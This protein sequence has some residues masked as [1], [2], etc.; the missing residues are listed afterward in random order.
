MLRVTRTIS[1]GK[2]LDF[3]SRLG[4]DIDVV[5]RFQGRGA[6]KIELRFA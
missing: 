2:L 1:E 4:H 3:V 6:G 5:V